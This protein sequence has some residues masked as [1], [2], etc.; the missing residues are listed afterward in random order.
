VRPAVE[1]I[2]NHPAG[3]HGRVER[4]REHPLR[5]FDL[6]GER[7]LL[8]DARFGPAMTVLGPF[9]RQVEGAVDEG[10][11]TLRSVGEE[12]ADLAVHGVARRARVLACHAAGF[13]PLLQEPGLVDDED[14]GRL[15][16]EVVDD[17]GPEVV[18]DAVGVPGGGAQQALD[19]SRPGLA[20]RFR[21][22]PAVLAL[23]PPEEARQVAPG[24]FACFGAGEAAADAPAQV[25]PG[26]RPPCDRGQ[27]ET[28]RCP[29]HLL[30]SPAKGG[31]VPRRLA[32]CRCRARL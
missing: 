29:V 3:G 20:H 13:P 9:F 12:D 25:D 7:G 17:V 11:A 28:A 4:P 27:P 15:V 31:S 30:P 22:L 14:A 26:I 2:G 16:A 19:P 10:G 8:G 23:H 18:A 6:G 24:P 32:K 5:Q 1:G 21:E